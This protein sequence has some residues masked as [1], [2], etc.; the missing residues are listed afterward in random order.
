MKTEDILAAVDDGRRLVHEINAVALEDPMIE[1][2][3]QTALN[4][5]THDR[6]GRPIAMKR[7]NDCSSI[8]SGDKPAAT[9]CRHA[10]TTSQRPP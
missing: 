6:L 2:V 8:W 5:A 10:W 7:A 1:Q 9:A 4:Q 3:V